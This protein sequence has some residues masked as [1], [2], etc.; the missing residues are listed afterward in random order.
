M[1]KISLSYK[2][3]GRL[4]GSALNLKKDFIKALGISETEKEIIFKYCDKKIHLKKGIT[5]VEEEKKNSNGNIISISKNYYIKYDKV[6]NN[7]STKLTIPLPVILDMGITD[8]EREVEIEIIENEI[9]IKKA[10]TQKSK[11]EGMQLNSKDKTRNLEEIIA[12]MLALVAT[13]KVNKGG[14]GKTFFSVQIAARL[15]LLGFRVLLLTSDSQNDV[16]KFTTARRNKEKRIPEFREGLKHWVSKGTG[17]LFKLR[18]NLDFIPL[19]N[20]TFGSQFL[21]NLPDLIENFKKEYDFIIIDSIPT[22]KIDSVFVKSSDKVIIPCFPD[23]FTV[24]GAINVIKETGADKVLGIILNKYEDKKIQNLFLN[25]LKEA[26]EGT[27]IIFPQPIRNSSE[28]EKL[29]YMGKTIWET[30]SKE[31][32][33]TNA[34]ESIEEIVQGLIRA[35]DNRNKIEEEYDELDF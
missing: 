34:K 2:K 28:I 7:K 33:I 18:E 13:V 25:E 14:I 26:I 27:D 4:N 5:D 32:I 22:M 17:D 11:E 23:E 16:F 12:E 24:S 1:A 31:K 29:L 9:L 21:M 3:D 6:K 30:A 19:E 35:K 8:N 15:A 20:N 10:E